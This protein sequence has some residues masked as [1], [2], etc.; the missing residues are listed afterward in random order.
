M[1]CDSGE[2]ESMKRVRRIIFEVCAVV[3]LVLCV[4]TVGLW[5]RSYNV[6]DTI[7]WQ[8]RDVGRAFL[9]SPGHVIVEINRSDWS[10]A[11]EGWHYLKE[12]TN[13]EEAEEAQ[14]RGYL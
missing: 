13:P 11:R 4:G 1:R 6:K 3:S 9:T 5:V 8:R 14:R 10:R 12:A 2:G 7:V